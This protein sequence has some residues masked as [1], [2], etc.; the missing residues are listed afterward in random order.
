MNRPSFA[1]IQGENLVLLYTK[2]G[3]QPC[4][5][6][7][8]KSERKMAFCSYLDKKLLSSFNNSVLD[9]CVPCY[10]AEINEDPEHSGEAL[11]S[12]TMSKVN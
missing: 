3:T 2:G 5:K 8:T 10:A 4:Q 9:W 11:P 12:V 7:P 6:F 1:P